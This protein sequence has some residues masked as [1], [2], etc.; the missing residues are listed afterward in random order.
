MKAKAFL[1]SI[2][3]RDDALEQ[4]EGWL[5]ACARYPE[6]LMTERERQAVLTKQYELM[7]KAMR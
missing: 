5:D 6:S 2:E 7:K 1:R 3:G 4:I